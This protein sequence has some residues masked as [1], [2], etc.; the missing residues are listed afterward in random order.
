MAPMHASHDDSK[1]DDDTRRLL[2]LALA[3]ALAWVATRSASNNNGL[4]NSSRD[5]RVAYLSNGCPLLQG[6]KDPAGLGGWNVVR[7]IG[8]VEI[9]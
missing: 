6:L 8:G 4:A 3:L 5:W 7:P 1:V 2:P 9:L